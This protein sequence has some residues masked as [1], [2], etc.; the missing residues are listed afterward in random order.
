MLEGPPAGAINPRALIRAQNKI[1]TDRGGVLLSEPVLRL[2]RSGQGF[3]C[4]TSDFC[5]LLL[6]RG[7]TIE[8]GKVLVAAGLY[9]NQLLQ[10][11]GVQLDLQLKS[12][13]VVL[14]EVSRQTFEEYSSLPS[15][16]LEV[17]LPSFCE[18][19]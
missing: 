5:R 13:T 11:L 12:E 17:D 14:A 1:F 8:A 2:E 10:P 16:L 15:L 9:T 7:R 4:A 18:G 6:P 3:T 19:I